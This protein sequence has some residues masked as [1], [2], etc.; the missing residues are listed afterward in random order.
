MSTSE[1]P[2]KSILIPAKIIT[3]MINVFIKLP[4]TIEASL[5]PAKAEMSEAK[6]IVNVNFHSI[7]LF[8]YC[9]IVLEIDV[10][11]I[12]NKLVATAILGKR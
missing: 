10:K 1:S 5:L 2:V 6:P 9:F 8:S 3:T 11:I 12:V 4:E 7:F